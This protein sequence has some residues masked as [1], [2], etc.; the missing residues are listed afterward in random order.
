MTQGGPAGATEVVGTLLYERA[1]SL[2]EAGYAAAMGL[3]MTLLSGVV[4]LA[5]LALRRRGWEV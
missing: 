1:F 3:S 4:M 5:Y 2:F